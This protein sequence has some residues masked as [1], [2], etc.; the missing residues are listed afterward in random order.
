MLGLALAGSARADDTIATASSSSETKPGTAPAPASSPKDPVEIDLSQ[1]LSDDPDHLIRH[2]YLDDRFWFSGQVNLIFQGHPGFSADYSGTN[3]FRSHREEKLSETATLHFAVRLLTYTEVLASAENAAGKGLSNAL[4]LAGF[5]N[6]DVVCNPDLGAEPYLARI[7]LHQTIPLSKEMVPNPEL[8]PFSIRE[9]VPERRIDL[10]I[11][12]MSLPDFFDQNEV[13]SD[14]HFQF[15]NWAS[16][17]DAAWDY[18]ADTRGYT[19]AAFAEYQDSLF[20]ARFAAAVMPRV[21]NGI[22]P[23]WR[24][25]QAHAEELELEVHG[26]AILDRHGAL[27]VLGYMNHARMG[28]YE[29]SVRRFVEGLDPL[30]DITSTRRARRTKYGICVNVEQELTEI[31]RVY[32]RFGWN[33]GRNES[34]AY[35]E[36][37]NSFAAG[38]DVRGDLWKRER[39]RFGATFVSNGLGG[40]H[41][42][43]L[44][45]GGLG[46]L[47]GDGTLRYDREMIVE[48][49]YTFR[50]PYGIS[51]GP[52]FQ[53][54]WNPGYNH[55]R[56]AVDVYG[57]RLHLEI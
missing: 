33:D 8:G 7:I 50:L 44:K 20:A 19:Y 10:R 18:A 49:Y 40:W 42:R 2:S 14:G 39:D 27:R 25:D 37:E 26:D 29:E 52:L 6:V 4:G 57:L 28:E 35:T 46:F 17:N 12:K 31:L 22:D 24:L 15:T 13:G 45:D 56:G 16:V 1:V 30:P 11:G 23:D 3:S 41:R 54:I 36:C 47:L 48:T 21:A 53:H 34:F 32:G 55:D 43:Y 9:K 5:T 51:C 38:F